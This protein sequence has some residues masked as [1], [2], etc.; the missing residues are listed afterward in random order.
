MA[1]MIFFSQLSYNCV[2]MNKEYD[3]TKDI[4]NIGRAATNDIVIPN[5]V[6]FKQLSSDLQ[7]A[8][9]NELKR[10]SRLHAIITRK[11]GKWYVE[12]VGT[13]GLG[14][15]YGTFVNGM[16]I[17]SRKPC[18]LHDQDKISFGP[19]ECFF[20]EKETVESR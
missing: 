8:L 16:K 13:K 20:S 1:Q 19:I 17:D 12:D 10:V 2:L 9:R 7:A 5:D 18:L 3:L 11:E 14:S 15:K 4:I 6:L